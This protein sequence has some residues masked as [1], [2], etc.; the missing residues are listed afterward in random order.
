M[1]AAAGTVL[2][3]PGAGPFETSSPPAN[4]IQREA[5][6]ISGRRKALLRHGAANGPLPS[7]GVIIATNRPTMTTNW[8]PLMAAQSHRPESVAV[9]TH[10]FSLEPDQ[11]E[12]IESLAPAVTVSPATAEA[13]LGELLNTA[14][15]TS[16][17]D[18]IVKWDDDDWYG[19]DHLLDLALASV[20]SGADI[21]GK[22]AEFI[23]LPHADLT[24]RR[25]SAGAETFSRGL[26]GATLA[27]RRAAFER[28]EGFEPKRTGEDSDLIDRAIRLGLRTYR[29]HGFD[30]LVHRSDSSAWQSDERRFIS[31]SSWR[32]P[33]RWVPHARL[34]SDA[35]R[36]EHP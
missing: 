25:F 9:V 24:V 36:E 13:P 30:F 18:L 8:V 12:A 26:S 17:S 22:G 21:V 15:A 33:G 29:T 19:T 23:Y 34:H 3:G 35:E 1:L 7:V 2:V 6:S 32:T 4:E 10:G 14:A 16:S 11:Q 20:Y 31:Q 5:A 27:L 28:L